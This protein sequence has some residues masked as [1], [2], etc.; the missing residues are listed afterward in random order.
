MG[1]LRNVGHSFLEIILEKNTDNIVRSVITAKVSWNIAKASVGTWW[2]SVPKVP[3]KVFPSP[4]CEKLPM[5]PE[6]RPLILNYKRWVEDQGTWWQVRPGVEQ[7]SAPGLFPPW[8]NRRYTV[9]SKSTGG[10]APSRF[11]S[12]CSC[13]SPR[14]RKVV[15]FT[16]SYHAK[17]ECGCYRNVCSSQTAATKKI[18]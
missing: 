16:E 13:Q 7:I 9:D 6:V 15:R 1:K 2:P 10:N 8:W 3:D 18:W 11:E 14:L 4:K 17:S 12:E 5:K